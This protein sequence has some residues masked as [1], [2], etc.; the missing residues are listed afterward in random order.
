ERPDLRLAR[1]AG[2]AS[3]LAPEL[4][5]GAAVVFLD[6]RDDDGPANVAVEML[7]ADTEPA[8]PVPDATPGDL[9]RR[10]AALG[11]A[12]SR[13][14]SVTL[15]GGAGEP[16]PRGGAGGDDAVALAARCVLRLL[17]EWELELA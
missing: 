6:A 1:A 2:F 3:A 7:R 14:A 15:L 17:E 11:A 5:R 16:E 8:S 12:P 10:A 4:A 9:L 13:A